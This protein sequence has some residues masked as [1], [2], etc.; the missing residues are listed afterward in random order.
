M[1]PPIRDFMATSP[2]E[3]LAGSGMATVA[4]DEDNLAR[5]GD[6]FAV[7]GEAAMGCQ[8]LDHS[9]GFRSPQSLRA[10]VVV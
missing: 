10:A 7:D 1:S 2:R 9:F 3:Q 5:F 8:V 6:G 4:I